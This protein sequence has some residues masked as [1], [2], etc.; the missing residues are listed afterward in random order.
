MKVKEKT[1]ISLRGRVIEEFEYSNNRQ[2]FTHIK[3][4]MKKYPET[5]WAIMQETTYWND[6]EHTIVTGDFAGSVQAMR[7]WEKGFRG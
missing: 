4:I 3:R 1:I 7:I 2:W 6:E 5:D